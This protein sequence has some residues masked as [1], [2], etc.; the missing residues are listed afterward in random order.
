MILCP[1]VFSSPVCHRQH[2]TSQTEDTAIRFQTSI[3]NSHNLDMV[4]I[5]FCQAIN[6]TIEEILLSFSYYFLIATTVTT[7]NLSQRLFKQKNNFLGVSTV[8]FTII[9][10]N[11]DLH[12]VQRYPLGPI[13]ACSL[14][15]FKNSSPPAIIYPFTTP[16]GR[17]F[18]NHQSTIEWFSLCFLDIHLAKL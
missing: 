15:K 14:K 8:V 7:P 6:P 17:S 5:G 13:P 1:L 3:C 16:K 9:R 11:S 4:S 12:F 2:R 18:I 10:S